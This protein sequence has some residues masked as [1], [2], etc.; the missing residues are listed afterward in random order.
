MADHTPPKRTPSEEHA[1]RRKRKI[2][3]TEARLGRAFMN[4]L[5]CQEETSSENDSPSFSIS[6]ISNYSPVRGDWLAEIA[7]GSDAAM[8]VVATEPAPDTA[9]IAFACLRDGL[10]QSAIRAAVDS[11]VDVPRLLVCIAFLIVT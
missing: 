5:G 8:A 10:P 11:K 2:Y 9:A 4:D 6:T 1:L 7:P 3:H